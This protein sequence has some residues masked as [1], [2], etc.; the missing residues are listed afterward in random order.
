MKTESKIP[1]IEQEI[2]EIKD[3]I[4][5]PQPNNTPDHVDLELK[6]DSPQD[7]WETFL[8]RRKTGA[9]TVGQGA[10]NAQYGNPHETGHE[11]D[12]DKAVDLKCFVDCKD[13]KGG[14]KQT[15]IP[16]GRKESKGNEHE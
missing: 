5:K 16:N 6:S 8:E 12:W 2:P 7:L 3:E 14:D 11:S 13:V 1:N 9:P 10:G 15:Y 4:K